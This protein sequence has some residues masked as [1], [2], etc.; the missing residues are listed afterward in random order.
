VKGDA[1]PQGPDSGRSKWTVAVWVAGDNNLDSFGVTDLGELKK[2]GSSADVAVVAQFDRMGD[3]KTRRYYLRE[4]TSL[5]ADVVEELGETD[6]GDP[7]VAIDFF[8]WAIGK[9]PSERVLTVIWNHGSGIDETDIYARAAAVDAGTVPRGRVREIAA[10]GHRRALFST[11]VDQAVLERAIAYDDTSRDFLDNK[12]LQNVLAEVVKQTKRRIDILG[13]DAC[14]MNMVEVAYQLRDSVDYIVGSEEVE[15]GDGW[16]YEAQLRTLDGS[17]DA[18]AKDV[19]PKLVKNYLESYKN[20]G[21]AITQSAVDVSRVGDV[22]EATKALA[23]ASVSLVGDRG[24][25]AD[26]SKAVKNAQRFQMK[27]FADFGDLCKRLV[28]G[29]SESSVKDAVQAVDDSL[30]GGSPFVIAAGKQGTSVQGATGTSIYF[31]IVGDVQVAY[32]KLDFAHDS[33]WGELI[34]TYQQA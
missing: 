15:P 2:V 29:S 26:F 8:T 9:W 33:G 11:T 17:P 18:A 20:G 21:E 5:D 27:D 3:G 14:L 22:A 6:T 28:D 10:S 13:F 4:G 16:P 31:P 30:F 12:E 32:D 19:A 24:G 23:A 25:F 34:T 1:V 7:K